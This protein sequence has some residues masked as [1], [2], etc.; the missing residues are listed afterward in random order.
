VQGPESRGV[1]Y[2]GRRDLAIGFG[3]FIAALAAVEL[4]LGY[5]VAGVVRALFIAALI[6]TLGVVL[7]RA[8]PSNWPLYLVTIVLVATL[9]SALGIIFGLLAE[10]FDHIAVLTTF[11]ITPLVFVGGVFTSTQFL[12][13]IVRE[14]SLV[15]PMFHMIDAFRYSYTSRGDEPLAVALAVVVVL[16]SVAFATALRMTAL[17]VKLRA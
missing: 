3:P 2:Q 17:G 14:I 9:F 15:N 6:T 12:P 4:V 1:T 11:A 16:A 5:I 13:P 10:K 7:V 8:A